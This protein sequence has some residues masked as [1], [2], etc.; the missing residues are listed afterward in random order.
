MHT[1]IPAFI[2]FVL[3]LVVA[4]KEANDRRAARGFMRTNVYRCPIMA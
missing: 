1:F 3:E 2:R 4:N